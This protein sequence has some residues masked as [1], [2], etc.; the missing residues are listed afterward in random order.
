MEEVEEYFSGEMRLV[1]GASTPR[2]VE[3]WGFLARTTPTQTSLGN[4]MEAT[5]PMMRV[6]TR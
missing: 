5:D 1:R 2:L 6:T 4:E 3:G